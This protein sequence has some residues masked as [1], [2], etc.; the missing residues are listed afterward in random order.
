MSNSLYCKSVQIKKLKFKAAMVLPR[1]DFIEL[2]DLNF[3]NNTE[4]SAL[5]LLSHLCQISGKT[6]TFKENFKLID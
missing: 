4:I 6:S 1:Y 3:D 2:K 5:N